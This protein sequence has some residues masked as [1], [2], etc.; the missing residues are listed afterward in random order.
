[1]FSGAGAE[2]RFEEIQS[3]GPHPA[4]RRPISTSPIIETDERQIAP[5]EPATEIIAE[6]EVRFV[7]TR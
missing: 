3:G 6:L 2:F 1:L 4:S 5:V 7:V